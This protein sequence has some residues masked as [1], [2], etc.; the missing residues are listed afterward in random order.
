MK[1]KEKKMIKYTVL[2]LNELMIEVVGAMTKR[3][4]IK[5]INEVVNNFLDNGGDAYDLNS[6]LV[7]YYNNV[8]DF[9]DVEVY[10]DV[11][12][13]SDDYTVRRYKRMYD[14]TRGNLKAIKGYNTGCVVEYTTATTWRQAWGF[15]LN[16][17][18]DVNN[19]IIKDLVP[20]NIKRINNK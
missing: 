2:T 5:R 12:L 9:V 6:L 10:E 3:I 17:Y 14:Y 7:N 4:N 16:K 8:D 20:Y 13:S 11:D 1:E 19:I 15:N 18:V